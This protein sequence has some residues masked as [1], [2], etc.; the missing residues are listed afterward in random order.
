MLFQSIPFGFSRG[1]V[2]GLSSPV[3]RVSDPEPASSFAS[4][5]PLATE[6]SELAA[7]A[8]GELA[9]GP[10]AAPVHVCGVSS[11]VEGSPPD[12][13]DGGVAGG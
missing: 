10:R 7:S 9:A 11:E 6:A 5:P 12:E 4:A 8:A 1:N 3:G 2:R 13:D